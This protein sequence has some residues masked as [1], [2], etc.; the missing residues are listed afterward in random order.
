MCSTVVSVADTAAS[1]SHFQRGIKAP[2]PG[3]VMSHMKSPWHKAYVIRAIP[4]RSTGHLA[5][6]RKNQTSLGFKNTNML[7]GCGGQGAAPLGSPC[8]GVCCGGRSWPPTYRSTP[9]GPQVSMEGHLSGSCS[10]P[11]A[12]HGRCTRVVPL[13]RTV[14]LHVTQCVMEMERRQCSQ[15]SVTRIQVDSWWIWESC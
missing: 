10:Q 3:F 5:S 1:V 11:V 4:G 9:L 2:G 7:A 13:Q 14:G 8:K 15:E 6:G 12:K